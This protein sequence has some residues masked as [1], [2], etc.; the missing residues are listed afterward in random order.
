MKR[1]IS[2]I[3]NIKDEQI[4]KKWISSGRGCLASSR[5]YKGDDG[6]LRYWGTSATGSKLPRPWFL[7]EKKFYGK[8]LLQQLEND[9]NIIN[10][11]KAKTEKGKN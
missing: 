5:I 6:K 7:E 1:D 9:T 4:V 3:V 8:D 2:E 10:N 11:Q